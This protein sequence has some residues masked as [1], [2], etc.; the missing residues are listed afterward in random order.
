MGDE[1]PLENFHIQHYEVDRL[2]KLKKAETAQQF[3]DSDEILKQAIQKQRTKPTDI[4][5]C[6]IHLKHNTG[7]EVPCDKRNQSI[8][9]TIRDGPHGPRKKCKWEK[10]PFTLRSFVGGQT[11]KGKC[12]KQ[13]DLTEPTE[14]RKRTQI[15]KNKLTLFSDFDTHK[16]ATDNVESFKLFIT[17]NLDG[18]DG[19]TAVLQDTVEKTTDGKFKA[20]IV[21]DTHGITTEKLRQVAHEFE[22]GMWWASQKVKQENAGCEPEDAR[23]KYKKCKPHEPKKRSRGFRQ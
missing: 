20:K 9:E 4:N 12:I 7:M 19:S 22:L 17:N 15:N 11:K 16:E 3:I 2:K 5:K 13:C 23:D 21:C 1:C 14:C 18:D 6:D 8:C 10:P